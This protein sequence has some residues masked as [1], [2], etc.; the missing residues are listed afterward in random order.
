MECKFQSASP[1]TA[2]VPDALSPVLFLEY[3]HTFLAQSK[4]ILDGHSTV[5]IGR[6]S[7]NCS[8]FGDLEGFMGEPERFE[9]TDIGEMDLRDCVWR[10]WP[11]VWPFQ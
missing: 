9:C 6:L 10:W 11:S 1:S 8:V 3:S 5:Y 7:F 2:S 4:R